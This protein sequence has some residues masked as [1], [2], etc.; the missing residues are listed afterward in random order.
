MRKVAVLLALLCLISPP[1]F[2]HK[3]I[4]AVYDNGETI[5]GEIGFSN[6]DMA[7]G[8]V[9]EYFDS[10]Q[11]KLGEFTSDQ[12][13]IFTG[14]LTGKGTYLFKV[15]LGAGHVAEAL[16]ERGT[17]TANQASPIAATPGMADP[18]LEKM[19]RRAVTEQ[20]TPLRKELAAYK[21]KN[22]LQKILGGLG[23]ILGLAGIGF[24]F[25]ARQKL[26]K[27]AKDTTT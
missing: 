8:A 6:G 17:A 26:K 14:P 23:Y 25:S 19:I 2:A 20:V 22:D 3:V 12:D 21:E 9:V 18:N 7:P 11:K 27:A 5:E 13:G 15:N 24:Y 1:A 16:L 4:F 10:A